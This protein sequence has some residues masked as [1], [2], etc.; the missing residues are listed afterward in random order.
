MNARIPARMKNCPVYAG[1]AV[2]EGAA[3]HNDDQHAPLF[4]INDPNR[5]FQLIDGKRCGNCGQRLSTRPGGKFTLLLRPADYTRG[6]TRE[7]ALHPSDCAPYAIQACP[8]LNGRMTHYRSTPRDLESERCGDPT[9]SCRRWTTPSDHQARAGAA[10]PPF[11]AATFRQE[12]YQLGWDLT[13][14]PSGLR[15]IVVP[16]IQPLSLRLATVGQPSRR[17]IERALLLGLPLPPRP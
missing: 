11:Y 1:L 15:V 9:C 2:P 8:L 17:D 3:R 6:F 16:S 7:P 13:R 10:A 12:H 5:V 4:G 14:G